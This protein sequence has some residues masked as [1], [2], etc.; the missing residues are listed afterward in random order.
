MIV[1]RLNTFLLE[2]CLSCTAYTLPP[3]GWM[4]DMT[5]Y[6]TATDGDDIPSNILCDILCVPSQ[7]WLSVWEIFLILSLI[8]M[9]HT[10]TDKAVPNRS[11]VQFNSHWSVLLIKS[12]FMC[13]CALSKR[14]QIA[15]RFLSSMEYVCMNLNAFLA[16]LGYYH[17]LEWPH[18]AQLKL[19]FFV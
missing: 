16:H 14:L 11:N 10:H 8:V 13:V 6:L 18:Y 15:D 19:M 1:G 3:L 2:T 17:I 7:L 4:S 12:N 9:C 5:A